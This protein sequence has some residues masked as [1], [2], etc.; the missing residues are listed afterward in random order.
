[1]H[2]A[3]TMTAGNIPTGATF[4]DAPIVAYVSL[5]DLA[6]NFGHALFDF[7]FPVYN[8]LELM[9]EY[10]PDFQL[11]LAKHQ[12]SSRWQ[13]VGFCEIQPCKSTVTLLRFVCRRVTT[14]AYFTTLLTPLTSIVAY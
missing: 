8:A 1:M 4:V 3:P 7:L 5:N 12:V 14:E 13:I 11:L 9:N 6:G 10:Q 2:W